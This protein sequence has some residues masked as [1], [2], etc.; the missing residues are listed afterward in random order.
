MPSPFIFFL[1]VVKW[2]AAIFG[3]AAA[4]VAIMLLLIAVIAEVRDILL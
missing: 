4:A 3:S 1:F 2:I